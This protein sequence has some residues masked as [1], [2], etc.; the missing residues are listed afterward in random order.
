M[1][2]A[3]KNNSSVPNS[4]SYKVRIFL[5]MG[6]IA[7]FIGLL[8]V[9]LFHL[10]IINHSSYLMAAA[11]QH[12]EFTLIPSKRGEIYLTAPKGGQPVLMATNVSKNLVYA[13][14]KQMTDADRKI[15][16][17]KLAPILG[18]P[19]GELLDKLIDGNQNYLPLL[20]QLTE[21]QST[22][23]TALKLTGIRLEPEDVRFYPQNALASQVLGF[24]GYKGDKRVGQ[25][26]IEG[27]FE[28]ELAGKTGV[29]SQA[30]TEEGPVDGDS[31]YLTLDR[32]IQFKAQQ[33]LDNTVKA[34]SADSGSV[35]VMNPKT[36]AVLAM[37]NYPDFDPNNYS[38][39]ESPAWYNNSVASSDYEP[40]SVFKAFT[41]AMGINEDKIT[42][43]S[44]YVDTG[45]VQV[46]DRVIKNSNPAPLGIQ[47]MTQV[48]DES[49]N[50]GA[51]YIQQQVGQDKFKEYIKKWGFGS[52][53]KIDLP[54]ETEGNL[55]QLDKKGNIFYANASFGQGITVTPLQL[56]QA[57]GAIA[58]A[59]QMMR[60]YAV[61]KIVHPD[62]EVDQKSPINL[63]QVM[64]TKTAAT[65]SAM[66][67][68]VVEN[69]HG[70]KAAVKGYYIGG[71]TGTA[72]VAYKDKSGYDPDQNIGTFVGFGP[73]DNPA[74]VLLVRINNP[75]DV[76][77]AES[78]A[79]PAFGEIASFILNYLQ[80][81]PTRQ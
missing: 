34:H 5:L 71:K 33:V 55:A 31:I 10:Q 77:F 62:G 66:L 12:G 79:A 48:L 7:G 24:L 2:L 73:A 35:V 28:Q 80:I 1:N 30:G 53:T 75:K 21:D 6:L 72:Q 78:T 16:A 60:P 42:P 52:D 59:G 50:T 25:Y 68:D 4:Y 15:A 40:G 44:T 14:G 39:V 32:S 67:V 65:T 74:F 43:Q 37:A 49:L 8:M 3:S 54:G 45:S 70:K 61:D 19:A 56:V 69:G 38:K 64:T 23:I 26:G 47:T 41:I 81:P 63:G 46:D 36:G 58:N 18:V 20:R 27:E 29:A 22:K 9:R 76:K 51:V 57:Y 17:T 11:N 13:V